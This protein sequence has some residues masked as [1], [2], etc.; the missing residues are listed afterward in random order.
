M[1]DFELGRGWHSV[2]FSSY[3]HRWPTLL[4]ENPPR[5]IP[6]RCIELS[7]GSRCLQLRLWDWRKR[8]G[9]EAP[10]SHRSETES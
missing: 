7:Y 1:S 6:Y 3:R 9:A 2:R 8:A 5:G 4:G 10:R